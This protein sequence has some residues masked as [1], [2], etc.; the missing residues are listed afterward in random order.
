MRAFFAV[1]AAAQFV[2]WC[3]AAYAPAR[4][5]YNSTL[6]AF[7]PQLA[8]AVPAFAGTAILLWDFPPRLRLSH[9]PWHPLPGARGWYNSLNSLTL[10]LYVPVLLYL[11]WIADQAYPGGA[12]AF[13]PCGRSPCSSVI[14]AET[15]ADGSALVYNPNGAFDVHRQFADGW[16]TTCVF[17]DCRYADGT[18]LGVVGRAPDPA[19]PG[20]PGPGPCV[21][22]Q[23]CLATAD[24]ALYPDPAAGILGGLLL[25]LGTAVTGSVAACPGEHA[26]TNQPLRG[27]TACAY[28]GPWEQKRGIA[29]LAPGCPYSLPMD[30]GAA[31]GPTA[32]DNDVYC[33]LACPSAAEVRTRAA[34]YETFALAAVAA[35]SFL[36]KFAVDEGAARVEM[37]AQ[38]RERRAVRSVV[39]PDGS[40]DEAEPR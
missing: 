34:A 10:L 13:S 2:V 37:W 35:A 4:Y 9:A 27:A 39:Q 26:I 22:G 38:G 23:P 40:D 8:A 18:G 3:A 24:P 11:G 7:M 20:L 31:P 19:N 6:R 21:A 29:A 30:A 1:S 25:G 28:C 17:D 14:N 32:A 12:L 5:Y 16:T 15:Q 33:W 36:A